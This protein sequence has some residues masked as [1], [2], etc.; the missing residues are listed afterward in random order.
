[1]KQLITILSLMAISSVTFA[2][3]TAST[4]RWAILL[5]EPPI[6]ESISSRAE[7]RD[8]RGNAARAR[9]ATSQARVID[10]L[11]KRKIAVMGSVDTIANALF[12]AVSDE[13]ALELRS[14]PGVVGVEKMRRVKPKMT[15]AG[16]LVNAPAAW[17]LLQGV[18][19]AGAG[20]KIAIL[21][22]GI[23]Q[24]HPSMQDAALNMPSGFPKC[25]GSDCN[26]TNSKVIA[27]RSFVDQLV[28]YFPTDTRPDDTSP[29]D[30]VGHG[31]AAAMVA[32]GAR[33]SS[34]AGLI[35]G[36]APKAYLG[37][38]KIFGSPGVNDG[39]FT[40]I[41][42]TALNTAFDD[43]FDIANLSVGNPGL[44]ALADSFCGTGGKQICDLLA[45]GVRTAIR[46]GMTVV[47][48]AGNDGDIGLK[49]PTLT[50]IGSPGTVPEA[51]TVG[52]TTNGHLH[53]QSVGMQ[54]NAPASTQRVR[55][56]FGA[57]GPKLGGSLS[58]PLRDVSTLQNN[59]KACA[60]LANGSLAGAV[61][62]IQRG[63]CTAATKV[64]IAQTAGAVAVVLYQ[65]NS[66]FLFA[67]SGLEGTG[68]PM[69]MIGT[70][71]ATA[72]KAYLVT[73]PDARI[74]LDPALSEVSTTADEVAFFSSQ[75]PSIDNLAIKPEL[76]AVG[77]GIYAATQKFD[78]NG[79]LYNATGYTTSTLEGTSFA[80]PMVAGAV[81]M[82]K[83][84][85]PNAT[86]AMLKSLVVNT[87]GGKLTDFDG[88][89]NAIAARVTAVGAGKLNAAAAVQSNVA[90]DPATVSFG[91][92]TQVPVSRI[93]TL[94]NLAA[95]A[96]T[97]RLTVVPRDTDANARVTL[98][99][100][101]VQ[102]AAGAAANVTVR[103]EGTT[104]K[105]GNYEGIITIAGG[106]V[107]L[108]IPYL[109][110]VGD[111]RPFNGFA[112]LG[113][114]W[115]AVPGANITLTAKFVDQF[116][117]PVK[118]DVRV[119]FKSV[120][121][122][123]TIT[124][125]TPTADVD[126]EGIV[127]GDV[128]AGALLGEQ[129]F[130]VETLDGTN[131]VVEFPGRTLA[132]PVIRAAGVVNAASGREENGLS[133][134]SYISIFGTGLS[135]SLRVAT[136]ASLPLSLAG[137]SVGFDVPGRQVSYPA[138]FHFVSSGQINVQIPWELQGLSSV[139]LK[140]SIGDSSSKI[141]TLKLNDYSPAMFEY[142]DAGSG[143]NLA[144]A[145]DGGFLLISSAN[146]VPRGGVAQVYANA[147]GPVDN[148]PASGEP[149]PGERLAQCRVQ[150]IVT[151][152]D[153]SAKV[154]F[155]GLAPFNVGLYQLNVEVPADAAIGVQTIAITSNGVSSKPSLL[156]I[157]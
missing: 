20:V 19:N 37:N 72:M 8:A 123:G 119:R 75:G 126:G 113:S 13:Q 65:T 38:Y 11:A 82:A 48:S 131:L 58:A 35:S 49:L 60:A 73:T 46:R 129:L 135:D 15:L 115:V 138:R 117:V 108:R 152:G 24:A 137:V 90:S 29:R 124:R 50:T 134:G 103:L 106:P 154:L 7:L 132:E 92:V 14:L 147:L 41:V 33:V 85:N 144:A 5:A 100:A 83:Q 62:L 118:N 12:V 122:G 130:T 9:V 42:L 112:L 55:A 157:K 149:T 30:R 146:P 98:S 2:Q 141:Y 64:K 155:C 133:P 120:V 114:A 36:I 74:T 4:G 80:A 51:I 84:K 6:A 81:A 66:E 28:T 52:A 53:F 96:Q 99:T 43:G 26:F 153:R 121:G 94:T 44:F 54:G 86:P 57:A 39:T 1:M 107:E 88:N 69:A 63:D 16:E 77:Q 139:N 105:P 111:G 102:L 71:A 3:R 156:P 68:I 140:V 87:A 116:G 101:T 10:L 91:A 78:P 148:T 97:L 47:I 79:N 25:A 128:V 45:S 67:V 22:T 104:P 95:T 136:T 21:D 31:T 143:R 40:D 150:P 61:A 127:Q 17:N 142:N 70:A 27:A 151:I 125:A 34:P 76:V 145:L 110:L 89:N 59:G 109:Y 32:A 56:I 23:D 93:L 18:Q